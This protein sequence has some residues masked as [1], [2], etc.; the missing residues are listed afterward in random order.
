VIPTPRRTRRN[1][2]NQCRRASVQSL[3]RVI[4]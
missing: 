3:S 2:S 4:A 1:A